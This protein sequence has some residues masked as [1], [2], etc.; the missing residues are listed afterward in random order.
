MSRRMIISLLLL[1]LL[2]LLPVGGYT[3]THTET[4]PFI[5]IPITQWNSLKTE[6]TALNSELVQCKDELSR[7]KKPSNQLVEELAQAQD[8]L[9]KLQ[10]AQ[11]EQKSDLILLS[12]EAEELRTS[13]ATLK[14][15]IS[16]ERKI[17]KRQIWQNRIW[18]IVIGAG[19]GYAASR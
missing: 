18:C 13:L 11:E 14:Q 5:Q 9:L 6:L 1:L 16:K 3:M 17:H 19:I 10:K 15:Q 2:C 4:E 7:I 12:K 8:L